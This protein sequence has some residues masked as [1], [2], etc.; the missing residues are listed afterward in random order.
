MTF[1][2]PSCS[3]SFLGDHDEASSLRPGSGSERYFRRRLRRQP[4]LCSDE[5]QRQ[6]IEF[7][8]IESGW[9]LFW[10]NQPDFVYA[11]LNRIAHARLPWG[12]SDYASTPRNSDAF[13]RDGA[14]RGPWLRH[15]RKGEEQR[16]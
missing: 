12:R 4:D 2:V 15:S 16:F 14:C 9:L 10:G 6:V 11:E 8:M 13:I 5:G 7:E 1:C 3:H